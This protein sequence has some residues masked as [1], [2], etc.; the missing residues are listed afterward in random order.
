[1]TRARVA[2]I[3]GDRFASVDAR[4]ERLELRA[5][6]I[7]PIQCHITFAKRVGGIGMRAVDRYPIHVSV[8]MPLGLVSS[9]GGLSLLV[10]RA[11]G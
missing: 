6:G 1:M 4:I 11:F 2:S 5:Q 10:A 7:V 3:G 8:V 9:V